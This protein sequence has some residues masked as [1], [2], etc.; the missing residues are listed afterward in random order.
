MRWGAALV[1]GISSRLGFS[2]RGF[3]GTT[4][5][6]RGQKRRHRLTASRVAN[7]EAFALRGPRLSVGSRCGSAVETRRSGARRRPWRRGDS[8]R[9]GS[10]PCPRTT[11]RCT[12]SR[13]RKSV[14]ETPSRSCAGDRVSF[15]GLTPTG[16]RGRTVAVPRRG[17]ISRRW[18]SA[19]RRVGG[20]RCCCASSK[21]LA[22]RRSER[23]LSPDAQ[24]LPA[25]R[26]GTPPRRMRGCHAARWVSPPSAPRPA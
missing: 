7:G 3:G 9:L 6:S 18:A 17:G 24:P 22:D 15:S 25:S 23:A 2:L 1:G 21:P 26:P 5:I 11:R 13:R 4:T 16:C 8:L 20:P 12:A 19:T 10:A 14:S